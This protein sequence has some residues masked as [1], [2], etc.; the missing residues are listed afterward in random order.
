MA[1]LN[2][3]LPPPLLRAAWWMMLA[4]VLLAA[5][6]APAAPPGAPIGVEQAVKA[7]YLY[8]FLGYVQWPPGSF[9]GPDAPFVIGVAAGDAMVE[10]LEQVASRHQAKGRRM[11]VRRVRP[12]D[13]LADI[14][15]L[16]IAR[17]EPQSS[18]LKLARQRPILTVTDGDEDPATAGIINFRVIDNR[19]RFDVALDAARSSGL[20]L[21]SRL[22]SV[23]QSVTEGGP[24]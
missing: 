16:Y 23:A 2:P 7:A 1:P 3:R 14:H 11:Q 17:G 22:L 13:S 12:G 21:S 18:L 15:L 19:I 6:P 24:Q 9:P 10:A 8:K 4:L 5:L 20:T